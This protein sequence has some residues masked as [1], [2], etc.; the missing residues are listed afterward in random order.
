[1]K[2][3]RIIVETL[4]GLPDPALA[5]ACSRAGET[6]VLNLEFESTPGLLQDSLSNIAAYAAGNVFGVKLSTT[7]ALKDFEE[8]SCLPENLKVAV[9]SGPPVPTDTLKQTVHMLQR[10]DIEVLAECINLEEAAAAEKAGVNGVIAKGHEAGGRIGHETTFI[11]LQRFLQHL[12]VPVWAKGGIGMHTAAACFAAGAAG[13]VLDSQVALTRESPLPDHIRSRLAAL[14]GSETI[15]LGDDIGCPYR[16]YSLMGVPAVR[17]LQKLEKSLLAAEIPDQDAAGRWHRSIAHRIGCSGAEA[18]LFPL[19]QDIAFAA[20]LAKKYVTVGGIVQAFH[21]AI[22]EH[23]RVAR[24]NAP[25][26]EGSLL[27]LAHNTRYPVV[28]GPMARVSDV[29]AF[30]HAVAKSGALPFLAA[31]WMNR[32]ELDSLLAATGSLLKD[33]PWGIGL[34]GFLPPETYIEQLQA[35]LRHRPPFALLAGGQPYQAKT[36]EQEGITTYLHVPSPGLMRMFLDD[37]IRR[38]VLEGCESGGHVGPLSSFV[39]WNL[40]IDILLEHL[41]RAPDPSDYHVLFAGGIHDARSASMVAVM[42]ALLAARGVR[43]GIQLGSAY[44]FCKETVETGAILEQYQQAALR[45]E[46]TCVLRTGPG[47]AERCMP[48]PFASNFKKEKLRLLEQGAS[49]ADMQQALECFKQGRLQIAAKGIH[50]KTDYV[51]NPAAVQ[52]VPVA[53]EDQYQQGCYMIGQVVALCP[54]RTTMDSLHRDVTANACKKISGLQHRSEQSKPRKRKASP[55]DVAIIGM[56]CILPKAPDLRSYWSNILARVTAITEIPK[57]R[58]NW[59]LY[60]DPDMNARDKIY[61]KWGAFL[62]SV[63]FDPVRYGIPP[64]TIPS[65]E[66]LQLLTL[67]TVRQALDDAGYGLRP[68]PRESTSVILG[69]SGSGDLS[70]RYGFRSALPFYFGRT[71]HDVSAHFQD[72]LPEWTEDSFPGILSNVAAGRVANRFNLGGVNFTVDA[73]CAS[74]LAALYMGIRELEDRTSDMVIVGGA[75][76]LQNPFTYLC[77]SKTKAL[78]PRGKCSAFDSR[79]DGTV[80]GEGIAVVILKR[81]TDAVRDGDRIYAV[82]KGIGASSDGRDRT[83]TAPRLEGQVRVLQHAYAKAGFAPGTVGLIEAHGTGTVVG[84]QIEIQALQQVFNQQDGTSRRCAVGSVK[85]M[86]GH[87]KSAAGLASLIK[88]ALALYHKVLPPTNEVESPNPA[89]CSPESRFYINTEPR[90]WIRHESACPRRAGVSAFGFGGTNFH[91]VL[92]EYTG[93]FL[94]ASVA[95]S[96]ACPGELL[97]WRAGSR[98]H[99]LDALAPLEKALQAGTVE[100]LGNIA[101][102]LAARYEQSFASPVQQAVLAVVAVSPEDLRQKLAQVRTLLAAAATPAIRDPRGIYFSEQPFARDGKTVFLFPGQ[103]SQYLNMLGDLAIRFPGVRDCFERSD[104]VLQERLPKLL[105]SFVFPAALFTDDEK[106]AC[107]QALAQT[108]IAQPA[109]GTASVALL[110]LLRDF[111]VV[112]DLVAGHSYGEYVALYAAGV[113]SQ[114]DLIALSEARGR[115]IIET[116]GTEQGTMAAVHADARRVRELLRQSPEVTLANLNAPGQTVISGTQQ[117]VA[118]AMQ[119]LKKCGIQAQRLRV[120]CA[121]HSPLVAPAAEKLASYLAGIQMHAP[122]LPIFSNTTA[123]VYPSDAQAIRE[124]LVRHLVCPVAFIDEIEALYSEGARIF[125]EVGPGRTLTGFVSRILGTKPHAA[126]VSNQ[127]GNAGLTQLLHL[128][129]ELAANGMPLK[130]HRLHAGRSLKKIDLTTCTP[131]VHR[132]LNPSTAWLVNGTRAIPYNR[133]ELPSPEQN[134]QPLSISAAEAPVAVPN[135]RDGRDR[136]AA[137]PGER[138]PSQGGNTAAPARDGA[139]GVMV[140]FQEMMR[141]FLETQKNI[142]TAYFNA[143][144]AAARTGAGQEQRDGQGRQPAAPPE[145]G[146]T[147]QALPAKGTDPPSADDTDLAH[148]LLRIVSERTGYP[149]DMLSLDLDLEADLGIDSIKR[150]EIL[151]VLLKQSARFRSGDTENSVEQLKGA[152]TLRGILTRMQDFMPAASEQAP[153]RDAPLADASDALLREDAA[154]NTAELFQRFTLT[155]VATPPEDSYDPLTTD[156]VVMVTDDEQGVA[157]SLVQAMR[158]RGCKTALVRQHAV[159]DATENGCYRAALHAPEEVAKLVRIIREQQGPIGGLVHLLPLKKFPPH[160]TIDLAELKQRFQLEVKSLFY[161]TKHLEQD[162][163]QAPK[164]NA[165][166]FLLAA[167]AMGGDLGRTVSATQMPFFP[168]QGGIQGLLK[169]VALEWPGVRVK[170]VDL[171]LDEP[172]ETLAQHILTEI[173]VG[174]AAVEVGYQ[175]DQ[176]LVFAP[177]SAPLQKDG[178]HGLSID[179]SWVILA[180]GGARGITAEVAG[181]LARKYRPTLILVGSSP[182]PPETEADDTAGLTTPRDLKAALIVRMQQQGRPVVVAEIDAAY[183]ALCKE[184]EIRSNLAA[185][186]QAGAQVTYYQVDVRDEHAFGSLID[187][188]YQS[189]GT[190]DGVIHGA[191]IIMDK[192]I[193][194]KTPEAFDRVF[195]TKAESAFILSRKLRPESLKFFVLFSSVAGVFGN[196]G[197]CDYAAANEV[198]NK[199]TA[200]LDR[201]WPGRV[202]SINW[203]PWESA[204]MVSDG[205]QRQFEQ[206]GIKLLPRSVGIQKLVQELCFGKKGEV[207]IIIGGIEGWIKAQEKRLPPQSPVFPLLMPGTASLQRYNGTVE[208]V[209]T[210]NPATDLYLRDHT[211][212]GKHVLPAA[213]ALELMTEAAASLWPA[214]EILRVEDFRV[215][216]G[217]IVY[218]GALPIRIHAEAGGGS[219]PSKKVAVKIAAHDNPRLVHYAAVIEPAPRTQ[220]PDLPQVPELTAEQHFPLSVAEAYRQWLFHGPTLQGI[221][222]IRAVGPGGIR[223]WLVPSRPAT[224]LPEAAQGSWLID[225]VIVDCAFQLILL[226]SRMQRDMSSLPSYCRVYTQHAPLAGDRIDCQINIHRG[227]A[228][229][230]IHSDIVFRDASGAVLGMMQGVESTCSKELNRLTGLRQRPETDSRTA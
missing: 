100:D 152:R 145:H 14:D 53:A 2:R 24:T 153:E 220:V 124:Q 112:P 210:L 123:A 178:G 74:S 94:T 68:F 41:D 58:W 76:T 72:V 195:D 81:L 106:R 155:P 7:N 184:R 214:G 57:D 23:C 207:E 28:Q 120:S 95:R 50:D 126:L 19:G 118:A 206:Q 21:E 174:D 17:E 78:S 104:R 139:A 216:K 103:G 154:Q 160:Q 85:S 215:F 150:V 193:A 212:D 33:S 46:A 117:A 221:R 129:G 199:L 25:L 63:L 48:T 20:P 222:E 172:A 223:A 189:Y 186:R 151:G 135:L 34:L 134:I 51:H 32:Q 141:R 89:L 196:Q 213:V 127:P 205:L 29:P 177:T 22:D 73:A 227:S 208:I 230:S 170:A 175:R 27:A 9:L 102:T 66:P 70:Q 211:L 37:D 105:S 10:L 39:L 115:F 59:E 218:N 16:V 101:Y 13:I 79:A 62:D 75:D 71:A 182:P 165:G 60:Y 52:L 173:N 69:I 1:M 203:G 229:S 183:R 36:L 191:G 111:G 200:Y 64:N 84:D 43:I 188:I 65:I 217:V 166:S 204:G 136:H 26:A 96:C 194:D 11:L 15:C 114:D 161:L 110:H 157:Q 140:Q 61:S 93:D 6:G 169:T 35:V 91:A 4:P 144:A 179:S 18:Q 162:L 38:F 176:R 209:R 163:R 164:K 225:P 67:E 83:L 107:R 109:M 192:L 86:I 80:L 8:G 121:F 12:A 168:G 119:H 99:L 47:H 3:F 82:I 171:N 113:I 130:L 187:Q 55:C 116:S 56:A 5:I 108:N 128:L 202:V 87:T 226:W 122:R 190:I 88:A 197:Q 180:T 219:P 77:F 54:A 45:S 147:G 198:L 98:Q 49:A 138:Y 137:S 30:A 149:E 44:I 90:P 92:E 142:M 158:Y 97:L 133:R 181:E 132:D 148:C 185:M 201:Q 228:T 167:T 131:S 143:D 40:M 31:S 146:V 125:V 42:A 159:T 156:G 224:L